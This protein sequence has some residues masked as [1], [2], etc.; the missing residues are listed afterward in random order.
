MQ[1]LEMPSLCFLL[2]YRFRSMTRTIMAAG[3]STPRR[4]AK[5]NTTIRTEIC[6]VNFLL[7]ELP[8]KI[9]PNAFASDFA[10]GRAIDSKNS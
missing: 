10:R 3:A 9:V 6:I 4:W 1:L 7:A 2:L 8:K 5:Q